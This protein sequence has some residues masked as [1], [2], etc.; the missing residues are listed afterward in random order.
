LCWLTVE[1]QFIPALA[2]ASA[3]ISLNLTT[4]TSPAFFPTPQINNNPRIHIIHIKARIEQMKE[5]FEPPTD[6]FEP[7]TDAFEPPTDVFEPLTDVFE[8][9]TDVFEPPTDVFRAL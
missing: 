2:I 4:A 9:P 3:V 5:D 7:P 6:V 8:P 1:Q